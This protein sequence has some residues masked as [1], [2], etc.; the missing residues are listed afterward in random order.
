MAGLVPGN[1]KPG[2]PGAPEPLPGG[3]VVG[4]SWGCFCFRGR[5]RGH[6]RFGL[7]KEK[8]RSGFP[9]T[10]H[11]GGGVNDLTVGG[12]KSETGRWCP[13]NLPLVTLIAVKIVGLA[14]GEVK[15]EYGSPKL[16]GLRSPTFVHFGSLVGLVWILAQSN[17]FVSKYGNPTNGL[18][19]F[20]SPSTGGKKTTPH[21]GSTRNK[22]GPTTRAMPDFRGPQLWLR[23][24]VSFRGVFQLRF[25]DIQGPSPVFD[26]LYK[27]GFGFSPH[28][29]W[30]G[31]NPCSGEGA[32]S[33]E[34]THPNIP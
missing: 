10:Y 19:P 5:G 13:F 27:R 30:W 20:L 22:E 23:K 8:G 11:L 17:V 26:F 34:K 32:L 29:F 2:L 15:R 14:E 33:Y 24:E 12:S 1:V 31:R 21:E 3:R 9:L 25:S 28:S 4:F 6:D 16:P 7:L 18:F